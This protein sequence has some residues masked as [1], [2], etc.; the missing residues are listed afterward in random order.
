MRVFVKAAIGSMLF[1]FASLSQSDRP[2]T[3]ASITLPTC[4]DYAKTALQGDLDQARL[5][6]CRLQIEEFRIAM[7]PICEL[8]ANADPKNPFARVA[9][10]GCYEH[11]IAGFNGSLTK[12]CELYASVPSAAG[13]SRIDRCRSLG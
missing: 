2:D 13:A 7:V 8:Y 11:S 10:G 12:A 3:S 6:K 1:V 5:L 9:L 4:V